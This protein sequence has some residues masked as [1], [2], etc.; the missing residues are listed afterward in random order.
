MAKEPKAAPAKAKAKAPT[1]LSNGSSHTPRET[2]GRSASANK[3]A[4]ATNGG[5]A[6]S[7]AD[8][9]LI[10]RLRDHLGVGDG[11]A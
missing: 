5:S 9:V 11:A 8:A 3:A 10:K 4:E 1:R 6:V 7:D 2:T